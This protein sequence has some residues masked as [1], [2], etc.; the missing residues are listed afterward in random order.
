VS[1]LTG[2]LGGA[3]PLPRLSFADLGPVALTAL[4]PTAQAVLGLDEAHL[5][6]RIA[7]A[8]A[9]RRHISLERARAEVVAAEST[10]GQLATLAQDTWAGLKQDPRQ[11]VA[12]LFDNL[13]GF[14]ETALVQAALTKVAELA[15][16]LVGE[17]IAAVQAVSSL[18]QTVLDNAGALKAAF[19]VIVGQFARLAER[20]DDAL[21]ASIGTGLIGPQLI[22]LIPGALTFLARFL[23]LEGIRN[24]LQ[25]L[26]AKVEGSIKAPLDHIVNA[27]VDRLVAMRGHEA[28]TAPAHPSPAHGGA[29]TP[30]ATTAGHDLDAV[31]AAAV[32]AVD[33]RVAASPET[34]LSEEE[35][36][37]VL[38]RVHAAHHEAEDYTLTPVVEG[39]HWA[40]RGVMVVPATPTTAQTPPHHNH[41]H[42]GTQDAAMTLDGAGPAARG[43]EV[44]RARSDAVWTV[45]AGTRT[46]A[47]EQE[48][49]RQ[50]GTEALVK[51]VDGRAVPRTVI[52]HAA[53]NSHVVAAPLTKAPPAL[54]VG[55]VTRELAGSRPGADP[56]GWD[57]VLAFDDIYESADG[58]SWQ[59]RYWVLMHLL[60][61]RLHGPG[62]PWNTVPAGKTDNKDMEYGPEK[63]AKNALDSGIPALYYETSI[64]FRQSSGYTGKDAVDWTK[65]PK[66][67][68]VTV[69]TAKKDNH[70][71]WVKDK[72]LKTPYVFSQLREPRLRRVRSMLVDLRFARQGELM[73]RLGF[74]DRLSRHW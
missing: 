46:A 13:R 32:T 56:P 60:S 70:G 31:L 49:T 67:V 23:Q 16:P 34:P 58:S 1:W 33:A 73:K 61:E 6:D 28:T 55:S 42:A 21:A 48:L 43:D 11:L 51:V 2:A 63:D 65:F 3:I 25:A 8:Y 38:T 35:V 17:I 20:K 57:D 10:L 24:Q 14:V 12:E 45:R 44:G 66:A 41:P 26:V 53:D 47:G 30:S 52:Q 39:T 29:S 64:T 50:R 74:L 71:K 62:E 9:R 7:A 37:A 54:S 27:V 36:R 40:V 72:E 5:L 15:A 18:V 59:P 69:A 19:G 22:G 68:T 4:I